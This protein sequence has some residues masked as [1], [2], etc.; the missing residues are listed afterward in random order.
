MPPI[1]PQPETAKSTQHLSPTAAL[2]MASVLLLGG[3]FAWLAFDNFSSQTN[4]SWETV[5]SGQPYYVAPATPVVP[6]TAATS[7]AAAAGAMT[8]AQSTSSS[9]T[10]A[11]SAPKLPPMFDNVASATV[12]LK[13]DP[14]PL[15][16]TYGSDGQIHDDFSP[17]YF[18]VP[19]GKTIH[20]TV[21]NYDTMWHTFTSPVLGLNVWIPP[22][23]A[24]PSKVTFSFTA[25]HTGNFWWLCDVPCDSY[26]MLTGGYMQGEIHAVKA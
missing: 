20:V 9:A 3:L 25:P 11:S 23:G 4:R 13:V 5:P 19:V 2:V 15:G 14:P 22:G 12:T 24:H 21:L 16:G 18:A 8:M 6:S 17:A 7:T 10:A 26:A 1:A